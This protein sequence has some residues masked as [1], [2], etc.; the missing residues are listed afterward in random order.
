MLS[1]ESI[2]LLRKTVEE[3]GSKLGN[4]MVAKILK[5]LEA[6]NLQVSVAAEAN[7]LMSN[8]ITALQTHINELQEHIAH[9][10]DA[11]W[12]HNDALGG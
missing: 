9:P 6:V 8:Q 11:A 10:G 1:A 5:E 3:D 7:R 2:T 12:S 4:S